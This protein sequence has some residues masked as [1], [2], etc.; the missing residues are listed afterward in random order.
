M[1]PF[2]II[3]YPLL[4]EKTT[5]FKEKEN[6]YSFVVDKK[7]NKKEIAWAI[8]KLFKVKVEKVNTAIFSGKK[9]RV[10]TSQGFSSDWKKAIVTLKEGQRIELEEKL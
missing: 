5:A 6:K 2:E 4:T 1:N 9:R 7:A 3:K 10:G 8:G